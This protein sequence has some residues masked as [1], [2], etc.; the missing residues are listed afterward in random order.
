ME[1]ESRIIEK[2]MGLVYEKAAELYS[3]TL[4]D[5]GVNPRNFGILEEPDGYAKLTGS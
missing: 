1:D 3:E 5:H 2:M 4:V